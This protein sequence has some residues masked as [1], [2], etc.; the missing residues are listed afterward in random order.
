MVTVL[1]IV[2]LVSLMMTIAFAAVVVKLLRDERRRSDARVTALTELADA[3]RSSIASDEEPAFRPRPA[4]APLPVE[5]TESPRVVRVERTDPPRIVEPPPVEPSLP[6]F[7]DFELEPSSVVTGSGELFAPRQERSPW[8]RRLG[9]VGG[10]ALLAVT[11]GAAARFAMTP[12]AGSDAPKQTQTQSSASTPGG[13]LELLSLDHEQKAN[14]LTISGVVQNPRDGAQLSRIAATAFLFGADGT[15]L[16]SGRAPL[17]FTV[18]RPGD[19]SRFV[20]TVQVTAPVARYR[21]GFRGEDGRIIG[22]IDRRGTTT[23]AHNQGF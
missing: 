11:I 6:P 4:I 1:A 19:E 15:F 8:L 16:A 12:R 3:A 14:T 7:E 17:D 22:H 9:V 20:I 10:I 23:M 21:V 5:R 2:T 13:L 18:L